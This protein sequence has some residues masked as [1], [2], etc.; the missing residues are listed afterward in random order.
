MLSQHV[1]VS[2][3]FTVHEI[4]RMGCSGNT[5]T[6]ARTVVDAAID[7]VGHD[8]EQGQAENA[9]DDDA[10]IVV[11]Q[12]RSLA[13]NL[14]YAQFSV[15]DAPQCRSV[16][17]CLPVRRHVARCDRPVRVPATPSGRSP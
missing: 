10:R 14:D 7:E 16:T 6:A 15:H 9:G 2:F 4:V 17:R 13:E 11:R 12:P 1:T 5:S 3:P 8:I